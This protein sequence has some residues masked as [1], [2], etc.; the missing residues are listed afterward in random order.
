[1]GHPSGVAVAKAYPEIDDAGCKAVI[2]SKFVVG[3]D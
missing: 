1:M 2:D 3:R